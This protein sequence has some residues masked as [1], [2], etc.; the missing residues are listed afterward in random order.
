MDLDA[1]L[2]ISASVPNLRNTDIRIIKWRFPKNNTQKP[3]SQ[4]R[5]GHADDQMTVQAEGTPRAEASCK[6]IWSTIE[7]SVSASLK[8]RV[9]NEKARNK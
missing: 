9:Y 1:L 8:L 2:S 6:S 5:S 7:K 3:E 4:V